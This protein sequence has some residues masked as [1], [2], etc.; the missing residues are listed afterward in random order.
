MKPVIVTE[1]SNSPLLAL[2]AELVDNVILHLDIVAKLSLRLT[3]RALKQFLR[4][5]TKTCVTHA[6][7]LSRHLKYDR[8]RK[9]CRVFSERPDRKKLP[10]FNCVEVHPK[11]E[12][13]E[14][15]LKEPSEG[16][17][18]KRAGVIVLGSRVH[19]TWK[20]FLGLEDRGYELDRDTTTH[21]NI[22][23]VF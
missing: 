5:P 22:A 17:S 16:L 9:M 7:A 20:E 23:K 18:C 11:G 4:A 1:A 21:D 6:I 12:F 19:W 10:C 2:P 14:S 15:Q 8:C 3:C 13:F